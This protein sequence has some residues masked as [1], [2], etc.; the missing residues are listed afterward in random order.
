MMLHVS[1]YDVVIVE[2]EKVLADEL[3]GET[4]EVELNV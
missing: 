2:A 3:Y 4:F 1:L